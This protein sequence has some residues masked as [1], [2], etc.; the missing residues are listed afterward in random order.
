MSIWDR[1]FGNNTSVA[2]QPDIKFGRYSDAYKTE[3]QHEAWDRSLSEFESQ[4][5]LSAYISFLE[6]LKDPD[7]D[8]VH[9]QLDNGQLCFELYQGSKKINGYADALKIKIESKIVK[10]QTLSTAIL[11]RLMEQNFSLQFSRF[12]LDP[13]NNLT[14]VFDTYTLDGSPYKL[15][16]ALKEL[17]T[18]ADKQ[19]DLLMDE[20]ANLEPV[21]VAHLKPI[22]ETEKE[23]KY[24]WLEREIRETLEEIDHGKLDKNQYPGGISYLLLNLV[25][26]LDYLIK[27]EGFMMETL[28]R[29]HRLYFAKD[30]RTVAQKNLLFCKELQKLSARPKEAFFKEMYRVPATFGITVSVGHEQVVQVIKSELPK[31]DWYEENNYEKV[32]LAIPGYIAGKCLF[33]FAVPKL[34]RA[35][36]LLF[37]QI[38]ESGYFT[39]LGF[40][41]SYRES[42]GQTFQKK[43][44]KKAIE[45]I[46]ESHQNPAPD[47]SLLV[48]D[49]PASFARSFLQMMAEM[50]IK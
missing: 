49:N 22:P 24:S 42:D 33:N 30:D 31:M 46:A 47:T 44:I 15:Y 29:M 12:A 16:Y 17:A 6:Y 4:E 18:N 32:A 41:E 34:D 19:D 8:N 40:T 25:Y 26:K 20:F 43:A 37:F 5:Y 27:P 39:A 48:F 11:R 21:E 14:I 13:D 23:V 1:L 10:T 50:K 2:I 28:E 38:M 3:L 45:Q 36:F 9:W 35:L 7:E